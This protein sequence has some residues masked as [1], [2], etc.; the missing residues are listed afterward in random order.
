MPIPM[1]A[2]PD[3]AAHLELDLI[4]I[5]QHVALDAAWPL[6]PSCL[7]PA[8]EAAIIE[9]GRRQAADSQLAVTIFLPETALGQPEAARPE[10]ALSN[11]FG[12]MAEA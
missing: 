5:G 7:R 6:H 2:A 4:D 1:T 12:L 3:N 9:W 8:A 11:H 10:A